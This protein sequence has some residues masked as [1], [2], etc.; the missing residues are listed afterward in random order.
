MSKRA[1]RRPAPTSTNSWRA[2]RVAPAASIQPS[3]A[4]ISTGS[5]KAG[6]SISSNK[7]RCGSSLLT[8]CH[9]L[10]LPPRRPDRP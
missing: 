4:R 5:R 2:A 1:K 10:V 8:G 9:L 6:A 7:V 3:R